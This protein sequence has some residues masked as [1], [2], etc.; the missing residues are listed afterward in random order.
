MTKGKRIPT[1]RIN[2]RNSW[3]KSWARY[4]GKYWAWEHRPNGRVTKVN[5]SS[6]LI[7]G[8]W[9]NV[10]DQDWRAE[11]RHALLWFE[12]WTGDDTVSNYTM[13]E[14]CADRIFSTE[15]SADQHR[16]MCEIDLDYQWP[17]SVA[18]EEMLV[19][20]PVHPTLAREDRELHLWN[21]HWWHNVFEWS[22]RSHL[23][24]GERVRY[25]D[26]SSALSKHR[27][28]QFNLLT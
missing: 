9:W 11:K 17:F 28:R 22:I 3:R 27:R 18:S 5:V 8:I 10:L 24:M 21:H 12:M 20:H 26:T 4:S 16:E 19:F 14:C 13:V 2:D 7:R 6:M 23:L 1:V 25:F 15:C